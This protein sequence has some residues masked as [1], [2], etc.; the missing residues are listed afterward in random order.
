MPDTL[1]RRR[2]DRQALLRTVVDLT[3]LAL[4]VV[5]IVTLV[6]GRGDTTSQRAVELEIQ[7]LRKD[8]LDINMR[9]V[10][11]LE[12]K[13]NRVGEASD[14]YQVGVSGRIQVLE[15]RMKRLEDQRVKSSARITNTNTAISNSP[16]STYKESPTE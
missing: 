9:N 11:Y 16:P 12:T 13:I 2:R 5:L 3:F 14:G 8:F 1:D 4:A 10:L 6:A 15:Q 7:N